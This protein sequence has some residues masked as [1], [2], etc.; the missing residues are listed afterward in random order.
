MNEVLVALLAAIANR[1]K[2]KQ[3]KTWKQNKQDND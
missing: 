2:A 1:I 3:G